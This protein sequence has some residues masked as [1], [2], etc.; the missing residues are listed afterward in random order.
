MLEKIKD[1]FG[2]VGSIC[3][4]TKTIH[5]YQVLSLKELRVIIN[6]FDKYPLLTKK[7]ADYLLL[8]SAVELC[9]STERRSSLVPFYCKNKKANKRK[10]K[11]NCSNKIFFE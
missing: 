3:K 1:Y 10:I 11:Q 9:Y 8:K 5:Q 7:R 2:G 6:H 4:A